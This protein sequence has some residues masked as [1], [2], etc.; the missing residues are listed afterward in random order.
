MG[1]LSVNAGHNEHDPISVYLREASIVGVWH[2]DTIPKRCQDLFTDALKLTPRLPSESSVVEEDGVRK[3]ILE[4]DRVIYKTPE[5]GDAT[6]WLV[7][8]LPVSPIGSLAVSE[9]TEVALMASAPSAPDKEIMAL[10]T[11]GIFRTAFGERTPGGH[12]DINFFDMSILHN[13]REAAFPRKR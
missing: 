3:F 7:T 10:T 9:G 4:S 5:D 6:I 12:G 8:K 2:G 1:E 11:S 13:I